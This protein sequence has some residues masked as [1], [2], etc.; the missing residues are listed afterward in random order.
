MLLQQ[1]CTN[2]LI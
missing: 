2:R 1:K